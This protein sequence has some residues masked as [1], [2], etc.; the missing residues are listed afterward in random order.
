M[1]IVSLKQTCRRHLIIITAVPV[2]VFG[3]FTALHASHYGAGVRFFMHKNY[4]KAQEN[5]LKAVE[6]DPNGNAYY[7]LGEI[8]RIKGDYDKATGYYQKAVQ[9]RISQKFLRLA[10]W[11]LVIMTEK[12]GNYTELVKSLRIFWEKT[13]SY[14]A[15]SKVEEI[16]NKSIWSNDAEAIA[17]YNRGMVKKK[18][19]PEEALRDFHDALGRDPNFMAP[20]FEVGLMCYR[21]GDLNAA[22]GNFSAIVGKV[23]F[24]G[25][26]HLLMG[27][28]YFNSHSYSSAVNHFSRALDFCFMG[29]SALYSVYIKRATSYYKLS[30]YNNAK[31]DLTRARRIRS[32][33]MEPLL[34]L[35]AINIKQGNYNE[36]LESLTDANARQPGNSSIVFQIGSIYYK[37]NDKKYVGYFDRLFDMEHA[38]GGRVP[39]KYSRA[40]SI[41]VKDHYNAGKFRRAAVILNSLPAVE[42]SSEMNAIA[43]RTYYNTRDYEKAALYYEKLYAGPENSMYLA[44]SYARTGRK[45]KAREIVLRY[46][47]DESFLN[48]ARKN[49]GLRNIVDTVTREKAEEMRVARE[50]QLREKKEQERRE[51]LQRELREKRDRERKEALEMEK[52]QAGDM[53]SSVER[54]SIPGS[55]K[56]SGEQQ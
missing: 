26:V 13:G 17:A 50:K 54:S 53:N 24:Y 51:A 16:I 18:A 21:K 45:D 56:V 11:N 20:K 55:E 19:A 40:M 10:Y 42:N 15:K 44:S 8:E 6:H 36:A 41:L 9:G 35:S 52:K 2:L 31:E 46:Y 39:E 27:E 32:G 25:D 30:D 33:E 4:E 23:P 49:N 3:S 47:N 43:A 1:S 5:L 48:N 29:K 12:R 22:L 38:G 37:L 7:F 34:L 28:I 14:G